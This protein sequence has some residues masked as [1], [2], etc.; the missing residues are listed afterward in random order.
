[1]IE[2]YGLR[3]GGWLKVIYVGGDLF[4][5]RVMDINSRMVHYPS[6]RRLP[7]PHDLEGRLANHAFQVHQVKEEIIDFLADD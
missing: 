2:F 7:F 6:M 5:M 1:M 3:G 4:Y